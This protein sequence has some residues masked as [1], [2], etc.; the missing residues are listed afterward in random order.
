MRRSVADTK[1]ESLPFT[2]QQITDFYVRSAF[3]VELLLPRRAMKKVRVVIELIQHWLDAHEITLGHSVAHHAI[4]GRE[5]NGFDFV[6]IPVLQAIGF[7]NL[8]ELVDIVSLSHSST[9]SQKTFF[10]RNSH[11][12]FL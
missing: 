8:Q 7:D 11:L 5:Q 2:F 9:L 10:R 12:C 6:G 1:A 4:L 3:S